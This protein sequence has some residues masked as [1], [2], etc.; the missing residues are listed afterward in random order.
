MSALM[1]C[2]FAGASRQLDRKA[3]AD[4]AYNA[5]FDLRRDELLSAMQT[6]CRF[7][8][9]TPGWPSR[10]ACPAFTAVEDHFSG[11]KG[12]ATLAG[13]LDVLRVAMN[14]VDE[15]VKRAAHA[16]ARGVANQHAEV[17]ASEVDE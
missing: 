10:P 7:T 2:D 16:W 6:N 12:D 8:V 9:G 4:D 11:A 13:L 5:S 15:E 3:A 17:H 1:P 14:S